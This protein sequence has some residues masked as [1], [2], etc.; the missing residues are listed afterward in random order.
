MFHLNPERTGNVSG[1][2]PVTGTIF[3][4]TS[5]T[6]FVGGGAC[7]A[8]GR[9]YIANWAGMGSSPNLG[10]FCLDESDGSVIWKNQLAGNG[11]VSTPA[12]ECGRV[13]VGATHYS[14]ELYCIDASD[15]TTIWNRTIEPNRIYHGVASSPLIHNSMVYVVSSSDGRLHAFDFDGT[16]QWN[17]SASG[18]S[19]NYMSAATDGSKLFFGGGNAMNCVDIA[20]QTEEWTFGGLGYKVTTTPAV[21]DGVVYFATGEGEK[22]LYAVDIATGAEVWGRYLYGSLSSP[23]I[24]GGRIYIGD[25]DKKINCINATD[26]SRIWN[27]TLGE[28]CDSSPIVA[29]G[30]VYTAANYRPGTVYAFD[31]DD[32]TLVWSYDTNQHNMA[33]PAVS[34]GTLFIGSD[35]GY[36]YAFRDPPPPKGDLNHD[37]AVTPA[38]AVIALQMAVGA[39]PAT[40][41]ADMSGDGVVTSIDALMILQVA[42]GSINA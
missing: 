35:S 31:V 34:D 9:V 16:E 37:W 36:L 19:D 8:D 29:N 24:S 30:M 23:A 4:N 14:G 13:F 17:Y 33:Q 15:G 41:A 42:A 25:K 27:R 40:D 3:W 18:S 6:G 21:C 32:G 26:G 10:L 39:V 12:I 20:T 11:G 7:I 5:L 22:K 38:D 28:K 1:Y 2:A